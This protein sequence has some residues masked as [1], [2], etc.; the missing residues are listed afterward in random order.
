MNIYIETGSE[1]SGAPVET[2]SVHLQMETHLR[3]S[4][5]SLVPDRLTYL[6]CWLRLKNSWMLLVTAATFLHERKQTNGVSLQSPPGNVAPVGS[7][8]VKHATCV[9]LTLPPVAHL[10]PNR[11]LDKFRCSSLSQHP[12]DRDRNACGGQQ[13]SP[14]FYHATSQIQLHHISYP[15]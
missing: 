9:P 12:A 11:F 8:A 10:W 13:T 14:Y 6:S 3:A 2:G 4:G 7:S 15:W 5:G 1:V